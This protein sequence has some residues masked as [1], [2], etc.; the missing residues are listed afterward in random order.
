MK[1]GDLVICI[2]KDAWKDGNG[3]L[4]FGDNPKYEEE[5]IV[6]GVENI[7]GGIYLNLMGY[8]PGT[9]HSKN[10]KKPAKKLSNDATKELCKDIVEERV[11]ELEAA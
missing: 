8:S 3:N 6:V 10:F 7:L 4:A 2:K 11:E 9:Y 5:C 1:P